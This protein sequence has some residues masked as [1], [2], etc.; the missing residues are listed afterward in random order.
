[1]NHLQF[2]NATHVMS[3]F[4]IMIHIL[5]GVLNI[6]YP[7][8]DHMFLNKGAELGDQVLVPYS[9]NPTGIPSANALF[10]QPI[11]LEPRLGSEYDMPINRSNYLV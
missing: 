1:M 5:I 7:T 10:Q 4:E 6:D 11:G 2:E 3:V 9:A 8:R